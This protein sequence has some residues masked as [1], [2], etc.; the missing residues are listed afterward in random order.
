[1]QLG[2]LTLLV[3]LFGCGGEPKSDELVPV[4]QVPPKVMEVARKELPGITFEKVYR[5]KVEGKDA[6]DIHGKDNKGKI[7]GVEVSAIGE[8]ISVE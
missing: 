2:V 6:Y 8:L 3:S 4:E 7:R 1:M 5:M